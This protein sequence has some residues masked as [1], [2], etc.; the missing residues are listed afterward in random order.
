M[1][2]RH[3]GKSR[4]TLPA[5]T[6]QHSATYNDSSANKKQNIHMNKIADASASSISCTLS[7]PTDYN[8]KN[9]IGPH[10]LNQ[11]RA[12]CEV[13]FYESA[14]ATRIEKMIS[15]ICPL[16]ESPKLGVST[17]MMGSQCSSSYTYSHVPTIAPSLSCYLFPPNTNNKY[18]K[19]SGH[20]G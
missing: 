3:Q 19:E 10:I 15:S 18:T 1:K 20:S 8:S 17:A 7:L 11:N 12:E 6:V 16:E 4:T 2:C 14:S 5:D 9:A 13:T